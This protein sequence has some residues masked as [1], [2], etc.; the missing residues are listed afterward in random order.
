MTHNHCT[1]RKNRDKSI[2]SP[3][4]RHDERAH[5]HTRG[6]E[7]AEEE[8]VF[9]AFEQT[10]DFFEEG[11]VFDFFGRGAPRHVD[12]EEM[13]E[14]RLGDVHGEAAEE[15]G[16]EEEPFEVF[17]DCWEEERSVGC[18]RERDG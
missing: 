16:H 9:E 12:F 10:R 1:Q 6:H 13:A 5:N 8:C 18:L 3:I 17:E 2:D 14:E 15:D 11:H 7:N 4:P